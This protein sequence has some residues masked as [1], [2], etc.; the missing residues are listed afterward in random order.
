VNYQPVLEVLRGEIVESIHYGGIVVADTNGGIRA[1]WGDPEAVTY[2]RSTAKPIQALALLE[3]GAAEHYGLSQTQ[4]ALICASH[5]GTDEHVR[6]VTSIQEKIG[7]TENDLLC[8]VHTPYDQMTARRLREEGLDPTP[9]R[10]NCSGKHT[11][12]LALARFLKEPIEGYLDRDHP[13]QKRVLRTFAEMCDLEPEEISLGVDGCSVP[14][15]AVSLKAAARAYSRL[16]DPSGLSLERQL[17]CRKI[18]S[19]MTSYPMMVAG[20]GRFDTYLMESTQGKILAKGGAEGYQGI[21]IPSG[22]LY[23]DSPALGIVIKIADGNLGGRA[24]PIVS[25]SVL[26]ALKVLG[27]GERK[28]MGKLYPQTLSNSRGLVVGT[29]RSCFSLKMD[30]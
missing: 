2:L 17:A 29:L 1:R 7:V 14:T 21:G 23:P 5:S 28:L 26:D 13:V 4:I 15:Y 25:L 10:H 30:L 12:M 22:I 9:N 20:P 3:C 19:A 24:S 27:A 8:G 11:G 6:I 18:V 16:M